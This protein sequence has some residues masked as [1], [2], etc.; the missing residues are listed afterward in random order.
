M[1]KSTKSKLTGYIK[2]G[3]KL[4]FAV[5]LITYLVR[6]GKLDFKLIT[7]VLKTNRWIYA[8]LIVLV[9]IAL[10][11]YRWKLLIELKSKA[12]VSLTK[13]FSVTWIGLFFNSFL[14]GAVT[15][16]FVKVYYAKKLDESLTKTYLLLSAFMDRFLGLMGLLMLMGSVSLLQYGELTS[17]SPQLRNLIHFNG[18]MFLGALGALSTIFLG[19][20]IQSIILNIIKKVPVLG[21]KVANAFEQVWL[22]GSNPVVV[23]KCLALS[24]LGQTMNIFCFWM[25]TSPFY[26]QSLSIMN[27]FT[28]VPLGLI[29]TAI[30]ITPAGIGVGHAA[31]DKLFQFYNVSGGASLFNVYFV[32]YLVV[33]SFGLVPFLAS[34]KKPDLSEL[35]EMEASTN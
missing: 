21:D 23:L 22:M 2:L 1:T 26:D 20:N 34:G 3:V 6:S 14:P 28:F 27:I 15:G 29:A 13:V 35:E 17:R 18:L 19:K 7:E 32:I 31:F 16:D 5:V 10:N 25:M 8:I 24:L 4:V 12:K 30:P 9:Q 11:S 33:N